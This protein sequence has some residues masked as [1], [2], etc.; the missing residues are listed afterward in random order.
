MDEIKEYITPTDYF[1]GVKDKKQTIT[2]EELVKIYDNALVLLDKYNKTGQISGMKKLIF[3]LET[4]E[5]ELAIVRMGINTFV[6]RDD[7]EEYIED[8]SDKAV[9]IIEMKYYEREIPDE[10]V[11]AVEKTK[12][13]FDEFYIVF[14][15]YTGEDTKRIEQERRDKDPILFGA[16]KDSDSKRMFVD[17][18]YY[19]GDWEDDYCDLTLEK[20]VNEMKDKKDKSIIRTIKTPKDIEELKQQLRQLESSDKSSNTF[21]VKPDPPVKENIFKKVITFFKK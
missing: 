6:Y 7:I 10:I 14:T 2:D 11:E 9:K 8:I 13:L 3:Q 19:I 21:I 5:K 16:F 1:N 17:R 15:D 18:F 12:N 20:M 4:T